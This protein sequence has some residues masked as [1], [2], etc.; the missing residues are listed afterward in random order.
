MNKRVLIVMM[1]LCMMFACAMAE[2]EMDISS[3]QQKVEEL[4]IP[5]LNSV[6]K[7]KQNAD[8]LWNVGNYPEAAVAY[9]NY[10]SNAN[11]I[12]NIISAG[13]E[14]FYHADYDARKS[15][16]FYHKEMTMDALAPYEQIANRYK[17]ERNRAMVLEGLC[18]YNMGEYTRAMPLLLKV[19]D[20]L[21][22]TQETEWKLA[23]KALYSMV[24]YTVS[25]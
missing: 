11:W 17:S 24:G 14:P 12:A 15:W 6:E 18:Y 25:W 8:A 1:I 21:E 3:Q 16:N 4:G 7:M 19:L 10:A 9:N 20:I 22:E 13:L 23:M 2:D 5:T